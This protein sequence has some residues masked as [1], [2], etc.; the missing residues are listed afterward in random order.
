M[1]DLQGV[2]TFVPAP[3]AVLVGGPGDKTHKEMER[4]MVGKYPISA[5]SFI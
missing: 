1:L 3:L 5:V 4:E 2:K